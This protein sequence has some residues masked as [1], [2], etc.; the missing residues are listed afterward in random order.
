MEKR[1]HLFEQNAPLGYVP[2]VG[3]LRAKPISA[4]VISWGSIAFFLFCAVMS[5]RDGQTAVSPFF[6]IFVA[7]GIFL[8]FITGVVEVDSETIAY[9]T[10]LAKYQIKWNEV[11]KIEVGEKG[12]GIVFYGTNKRLYIIGVGYWSGIES[13]EALD[14]FRYQIKRRN[15]PVKQTWAADYKLSKNSKLPRF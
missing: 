8:L 5:W 13:G 9:V 7:F 14:F 3:V 4:L 12:S 15:I 6:L 10:P 11:E 1:K 2:P